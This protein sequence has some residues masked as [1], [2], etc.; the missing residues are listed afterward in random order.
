M[1]CEKSEPKSAGDESK[2]YQHPQKRFQTEG[3]AVQRL[4]GRVPKW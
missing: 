1:E 4:S 3:K 2:L